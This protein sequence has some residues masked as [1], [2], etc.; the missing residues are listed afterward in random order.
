M[1]GSGEQ[2][3]HTE[4]APGTLI[5]RRIPDTT[6]SNRRISRISLCYLQLIWRPAGDYQDLNFLTVYINSISTAW[7]QVAP[8]IMDR[9]CDRVTCS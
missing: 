9:G 2:T 5:S 4:G 7:P 3:E 8:L 6:A 1:L